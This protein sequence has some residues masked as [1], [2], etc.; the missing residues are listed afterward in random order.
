MIVVTELTISPA[1]SHGTRASTRRHGQRPSDNTRSKRPG[2]QRR[3]RRNSEPAWSGREVPALP[4]H[5]LAVL[6]LDGREKPERKVIVYLDPED[7]DFTWPDGRVFFK[8]RWAETQAGGLVERSWVF[9]NVGIETAFDRL[10]ISGESA[11]ASDGRDEESLVQA[12]NSASIRRD[13]R[14]HIVKEADRV[15]AGKV[16]VTV[17]RV[18][19]GEKW[20]DSNF[21]AKHKEGDEGDVDMDGSITDVTHTT[22]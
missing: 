12:M 5:L 2:N 8:N 11:D 20:N 21:H 16:V 15:E 17:Q 3:E 10:L 14:R 1:P 6:Y 7:D 22:G 13:R 19:L 18:K 9:R 4:Y